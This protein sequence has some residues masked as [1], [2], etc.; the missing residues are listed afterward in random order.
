MSISLRR[1][2]SEGEGARPAD[3]RSEWN[4]GCRLQSAT[5]AFVSGK[6]PPPS[7]IQ[8]FRETTATKA[9]TPSLVALCSS[10]L[11]PS[12]ILHL[13]TPSSLNLFPPRNPSLA[14]LA[15]LS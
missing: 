6:H 7:P 11:P 12:F 8:V 15:F 14:K 3:E 1:P 4:E 2:A 13:S 5:F 10:L 9:D